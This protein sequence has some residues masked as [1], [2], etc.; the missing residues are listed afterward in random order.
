MAVGPD[1]SE[2]LARTHGERNVADRDVIA[3]RAR[4]PDSRYF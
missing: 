4:Q 1:E 2:D 3:E